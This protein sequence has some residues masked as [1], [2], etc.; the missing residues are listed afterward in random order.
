MGKDNGGDG[1]RRLMHRAAY[2]R[3]GAPINR[4][5]RAG[6]KTAAR[7]QPT[8]DTAGR[9]PINAWNS[10]GAERS[11]RPLGSLISPMRYRRGAPLL[12]LAVDVAAPP[13]LADLKIPFNFRCIAE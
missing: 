6:R 13:L 7:D 10:Y 12:R 2:S 5:E 11:R 1:S 9:P 4:D 8:D 3:G